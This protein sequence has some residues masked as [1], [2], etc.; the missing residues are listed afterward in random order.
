M[1]ELGDSADV[2]HRLLS[3]IILQSGADL[4][5]LVGPL[6]EAVSRVLCC[7]HE[8]D[9]SDEA[10]ER[11]ASLIH[12]NDTVLIKGSRALKLERIIQSTQQRAKV[13]DT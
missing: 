6:M 3:S 10:I 2:E 11:I 4:V 12:P 8:E 13:S 5:I 9:S 1:L 7:T